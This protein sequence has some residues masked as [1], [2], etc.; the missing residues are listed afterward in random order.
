MGGRSGAGKNG[1]AKRQPK[2]QAKPKAQATPDSMDEVIADMVAAVER[3]GAV[4]K[5]AVTKRAQRTQL[6][7]VFDALVN[8]G[9]ELGAKFVR[10]PLEM[11]LQ[12]RLVGPPI[13]LRGLDKVVRGG[14]AG[15]VTEVAISL[16]ER[17]RA[18]FVARGKDLLLARK[19]ASV[20]DAR[21]RQRLKIV[22]QQVG[23]SLALADK[24]GVDVLKSDVE[25]ALK[26]FLEASTP[27]P[28]TAAAMGD[29]TSLVEA[30]RE[31]S[32]LTFVPK[33]VRLLGG[34]S[35]RDAVHA[36]LLRG[37]RAGRFELRPEG[38]MGRL[39]LEDAS[40]C[41]PG[42]QGS[43]LSWVRRIEEGA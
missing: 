24:K 4:P 8:A 19:D 20:L 37:A 42:P 10:R 1:L 22:V 12:E 23:A 35:A 7:I 17:G 43:H 32:G 34:A 14:T 21:A 40:F 16:V 39:S 5:T 2:A 11:Q 30:H 3:D 41:I 31:V 36:E 33:L 9:L 27:A 15:E 26:P 18:R 38:G 6:L 25:E 13:P 29:I 28:L